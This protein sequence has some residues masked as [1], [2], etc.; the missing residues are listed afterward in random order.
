M[1]KFPWNIDPVLVEIGSFQLRWYSLIFT[2]MF[3][4]GYL[5]L[6]WHIRRGGGDWDEG[7]EF[8]PYGVIGS[9]VGARLGHAFF[10]E[11]HK[12]AADPMWLFRVW[13]GGLASH[14]AVVGVGVGM[15]LF[16]KRRHISFLE[17]ADR[18]TY[19]G[20]LSATMVRVGNF[21]NSEIVGRP[22]DQTWGVQ[23]LRYPEHPELYRYPTQL[24]EACMGLFIMASLFVFD[25]AIGKE[26]RPR[27]AMIAFWFT[28]YFALR[29]TVEFFKEQQVYRGATLDMGQY[30]SIPGFLL[31]LFGLYWAF[32]KRVPA[33]WYE[34]YPEDEVEEKPRRRNKRDADVDAEF[35]RGGTRAQGAKRK[36]KQKRKSRAASGA[37]TKPV[38]TQKASE[39]VSTEASS[40]LETEAPDAAADPERPAK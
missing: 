9:I 27:G 36:K 28:L 14:G 3:F 2:L 33:G 26:K 40:E 20:T 16:C 23:F 11:P 38:E 39:S 6:A 31:G 12:L 29:F 1:P 37:S 10:Y 21:F 8:I 15:W 4:G 24:F 7:A 13:E 35:G 32:K 34:E 25:S 22:T 17:G 5:L 19:A 30:L 18:S